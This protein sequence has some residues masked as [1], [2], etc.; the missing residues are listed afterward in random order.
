VLWLLVAL[1]FLL[2]W[3]LPVMMMGCAYGPYACV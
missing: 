2:F 1:P 3:I